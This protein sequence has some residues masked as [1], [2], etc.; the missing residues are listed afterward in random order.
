MNN[1]HI[2]E[3]LEMSDLARLVQPSMEIDAYRSKMGDDKDIVVL[4]FTVLSKDPAEDLASFIEKSYDWALDADVSS[5]ETSDGNYLVFVELERKPSAAEHIYNMLTDMM[6]LTDQ[7]IEDWTFTYHKESKSIPATLENLTKKIIKTS[8]E[9][10]MKNADSLEEA[11]Q[12]NHL[13]SLSGIKVEPTKITDLQIINIQVAAG[14][15]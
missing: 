1:N 9:Y 2:T 6:N 14:I 3:G 12:L 10:E 11:S 7:K 8:E 5:G 13:R 4:N 15:K